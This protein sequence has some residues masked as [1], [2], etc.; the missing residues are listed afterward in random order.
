MGINLFLFFESLSGGGN[1]LRI[2]ASVH[3]R[4]SNVGSSISSVDGVGSD[5]IE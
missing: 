5:S 4:K 1:G 3:A 2:L